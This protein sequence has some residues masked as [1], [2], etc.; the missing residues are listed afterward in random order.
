MLKLPVIDKLRYLRILLNYDHFCSLDLIYE[1]FRRKL[2]VV[3]IPIH[4]E[5]PSVFELIS[6]QQCFKI[7]SNH[8]IK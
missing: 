7:L 4:S 1:N 8:S 6:F 2:C 5:S 3:V